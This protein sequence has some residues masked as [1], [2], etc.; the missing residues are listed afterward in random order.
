MENVAPIVRDTAIQADLACRFL[1]GSESDGSLS[2]TMER[3]VQIDRI[4]YRLTSSKR[5]AV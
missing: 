3:F 5:P 4:G 2:N 1:R